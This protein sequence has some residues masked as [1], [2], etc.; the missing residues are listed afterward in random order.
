MRHR[1]KLSKLGKPA[2]QRK[3]LLRS[4]ATSLIKHGQITVTKR[5]AR[6]LRSEVERLIT[7]AKNGSLSSRR[8]VIGYLYETDLVKSLFDKANERYANRSGGYTR[9]IRTTKRRGDGAE[10]SV[11]ELV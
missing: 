10:M 5:R 4:M 7:L 9:I 6:A 8:Q 3:A 11:I 2:D 1:N